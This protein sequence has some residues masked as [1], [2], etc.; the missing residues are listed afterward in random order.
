MAAPAIQGAG[1]GEA[2]PGAVLQPHQR[3]AVAAPSV[4]APLR[5][6]ATLRLT[7]LARILVAHDTTINACLQ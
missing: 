2:A 3:H 1:A 7:V 5:A 6:Q 4:V